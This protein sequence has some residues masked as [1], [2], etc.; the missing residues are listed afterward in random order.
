[1][2]VGNGLIAS[3]F[4]KNLFQ[5]HDL[6]IFASGVSNS[7]SNNAGDFLREETLLKKYLLKDQP[8]VYFSTL[9]IFDPSRNKSSYVR[10]KMEMEMLVTTAPANLVIRLPEIVGQNGNSNNLINFLTTK[11]E[12]GSVFEVWANVW[13][14]LIGISEVY[15]LIEPRILD[16]RKGARTLN[17]LADQSFKVSEIVQTLEDVLGKKGNYREIDKDGTQNIYTFPKNENQ[18]NLLHPTNENYLHEL[19]VKYQ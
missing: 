3:E 17:V 18:Y 6:T 11:I 16:T 19:L 5:A 12:N 8:L 9:S 4:K 13:R 7:L 2:I 15:E 14:N 10:H 1:M